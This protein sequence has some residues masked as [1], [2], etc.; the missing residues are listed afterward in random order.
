MEWFQEVEKG[1]FAIK[2]EFLNYKPEFLHWSNVVPD[3]I[4]H[5]PFPFSPVLNPMSCLYLY[6]LFM[7]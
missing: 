5:F 3:S 4:P 1:S 2:G 7:S 6:N